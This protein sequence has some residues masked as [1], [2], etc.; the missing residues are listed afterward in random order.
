MN[1]LGHYAILPPGA[2]PL[3]VIGGALADLGHDLTPRLRA[4][5]LLDALAGSGGGDAAALALGVRWHLAA[6]ALFHD[7]PAVTGL[8][9]SARLR[10][11][12]PEFAALPRRREFVAHLLVELA[13][14]AA[15]VLRDPGLPARY[16]ANF[17]AP[18][19]SAAIALIDGA[20]PGR[21]TDAGAL[22]ENFSARITHLAD[23]RPEALAERLT[24]TLNY[25]MKLAGLI[26][27]FAEMM[28]LIA[29]TIEKWEPQLSP[30][31]YKLRQALS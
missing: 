13:L 10:L 28:E 7:D 15:W 26:G 27:P 1:W 9:T 30:L 2:A 8:M 29:E 14:D 4:P 16:A 31:E 17:S 21:H 20:L 25:R 6:D 12:A 5:A 3:T 11:H 19:R 22:L 18:D 23:Q 24:R